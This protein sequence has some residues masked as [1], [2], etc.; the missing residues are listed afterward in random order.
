[1]DQEGNLTHL[2]QMCLGSKAHFHM[3]KEPMIINKNRLIKQQIASIFAKMTSRM[4]NCSK[5]PILPFTFLLLMLSVMT[6]IT[7]ISCYQRCFLSMTSCLIC[8]YIFHEFII[9][10]VNFEFLNYINVAS[11]T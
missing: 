1:M 3:R 7:N 2:K 4:V 5:I 8:Q 11:I 6:S 9:D 10:N